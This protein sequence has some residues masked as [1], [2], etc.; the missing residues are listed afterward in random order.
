MRRTL[1]KSKIHRATVTGA[2]LNYV[3][4]LTIDTDLMRAADIVPYEQVHVV[5]VNNGARLVTYAI[6]SEE[7]GTGVIVANGAAARLVMP[8]DVVI[9]IAYGEYEAAELRD[10]EPRV[11]FV[12]ERNR[13]VPAAPPETAGRIA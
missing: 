13:M 10:F 4:S 12:D 2:D 3:G 11:V 6:A 8:G 1:C 5:N 9:I 7:A